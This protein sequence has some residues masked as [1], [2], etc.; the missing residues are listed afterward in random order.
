MGSRAQLPGAQTPWKIKVTS[1]LLAPERGLNGWKTKVT[2][3][4]AAL[5][6]YSAPCP[7]LSP[8]PSLCL[9]HSLPTSVFQP[10]NLSLFSL[11]L[12]VPTVPSL[13]SSSVTLTLSLSVSVGLSL[14]PA[15]LSSSVSLTLYPTFPFSLSSSLS[16]SLGL[17][18]SGLSPM[19]PA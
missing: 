8:P 12:S 17:W 14:S 13:Y 7:P 18:V 9:C 10:M 4:R 6:R 15:L 19:S 1:P 5:S 3:K 16:V 2:W 11:N